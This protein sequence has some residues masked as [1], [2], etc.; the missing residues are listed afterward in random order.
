MRLDRMQSQQQVAI[1]S[2]ACDRSRLSRFER[3]EDFLEMQNW[4]ALV[5]YF[6]EPVR[7]GRYEIEF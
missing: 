4:L 2:N 3:D 5:K 1:Y 6:G 7:W